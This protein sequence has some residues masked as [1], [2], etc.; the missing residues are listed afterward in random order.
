MKTDFD[1]YH[2][3]LSI[4]GSANSCSKEELLIHINDI[5]SIIGTEYYDSDGDVLLGQIVNYLKSKLEE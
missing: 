1:I 3:A 5:N 2:N 4:I